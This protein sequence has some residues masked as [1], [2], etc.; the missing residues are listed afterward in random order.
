M[1]TT[2]RMGQIR[3]LLYE[4]PHND[5]DMVVVLNPRDSRNDGE[6]ER[7][8]GN[9]GIAAEELKQYATQFPDYRKTVLKK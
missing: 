1:L 6:F 8:A 9:I 5:I 2:K 4:D 3:R 7:I